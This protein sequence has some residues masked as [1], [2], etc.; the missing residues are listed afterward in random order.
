MTS[1]NHTPRRDSWWRTAPVLTIAVLALIVSTAGGAYAV[2]KNSIGTKHLKNS[3]VTSGKIKSNTIQSSDIRSS[4]I[5]SSDIKPGTL[6]GSDVKDGS[7][8]TADFAPGQLAPLPAGSSKIFF[9][10][11]GTSGNLIAKSAGVV[12]SARVSTGYY[13]V[14]LSFD[15]ENCATVGSTYGSYI[16]AGVNAAGTT[17]NVFSRDLGTVGTPYV[18]TQFSLTIV[19]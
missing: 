18:D 13:A 1:E 10:K 7:L 3:A 17:V 2:A 15:A 11:V 12:S 4:T 9:A 5:E 16:T 14:T 19:C 6:D 8:S